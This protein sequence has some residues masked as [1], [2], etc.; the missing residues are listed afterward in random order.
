ML[1]V[2]C[3]HSLLALVWRSISG[4]CCRAAAVFKSNP[5][6]FPETFELPVHYECT[7][8]HVKLLVHVNFLLINVRSIVF[9]RFGV[10]YTIVYLILCVALDTNGSPLKNIKLSDITI[11]LFSSKFGGGGGCTMSSLYYLIL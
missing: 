1:L 3:A 2:L 7:D 6:I 5:D 8:F 11:S 10:C 4:T 9:V